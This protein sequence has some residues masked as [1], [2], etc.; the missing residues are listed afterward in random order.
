MA[1]FNPPFYRH[2]MYAMNTFYDISYTHKLNKAFVKPFI[3]RG[4]DRNTL[5]NRLG[6]IYDIY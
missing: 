3:T 5:A 1:K 6:M 4:L 2:I